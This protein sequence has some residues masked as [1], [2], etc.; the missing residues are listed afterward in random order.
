MDATGWGAGRPESADRDPASPAPGTTIVPDLWQQEAIRGLL[1][2]RDVVV[3]APTGAG[4]TYVFEKFVAQSSSVQAVYT[5]PTRALAND[6]LLEWRSAGWNVGITT[7]DL[8]EN[9]EAPVVVA[10]LETQRPHL[11]RGVGPDLLVIDEYQMLNDPLRGLH[12]EIA[13]ASAPAPTQLLLLSGSTEN[14]EL[15]VEWLQRLGRDPLLVQCPERPV[16]LEEINLDALRRKIPA[17]VKGYWPRPIAKALAAG[18]GPILLFAPQR[19]VAEEIARRLAASLPRCE[20]LELTREQSALARGPLRKML[21]RRVAYHHSG[22]DYRLR[23]GVIEP[24]AKNGQ[25]RVVVATTGLAAGINF[26]LRSVLVTDTQYRYG[27]ELRRIRPDELL[28]MFGRAGRRGI[29]PVGYVLTGAEKPRLR[30]ARSLTLQPN[31]RIDWQAC[32]ITLQAGASGPGDPVRDLAEL[33]RRFL[34]AGKLNLGL[35]EELPLRFETPERSGDPRA[36]PN[37]QVEMCNPDGE[38]ERLGKKR[39][40]P[41]GEALFHVRGRWRPALATPDLLRKVKVGAPARLPGTNPARHGR[42]LTVALF[43]EEEERGHLRLTKW[44]RR[45]LHRDWQEHRDYQRPRPECSLETLEKVYLP[46]LPRFTSGGFLHRWEEVQGS[47]RVYLD[48]AQAVTFC[49]IDQ[50]G[51]GLINPPVR[52]TEAEAVPDLQVALGSRTEERPRRPARNW[53]DLGLIDSRHRP[54]R[55]GVIFSFFSQG[56][57]LAVA[58]G[59]EDDSLGLGDLIFQLA[60]LR[61]GHRFEE[62]ENADSRLGD[63]SRM[64]YGWRTIPGYLKR[65]VPPEYGEGAAEVVAALVAGDRS[66]HEFES[67]QVHAGDMERALLE[68]RSLLRQILHA[69]DFAWDRWTELKDLVRT[70]LADTSPTRLEGLPTLSPEQR[71][72]REF[73]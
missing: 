28:Q 56:E 4:K 24:L 6:K 16:P 7:G 9:T 60:N 43:P 33:N 19:Q 57:G 63:L 8:A 71:I 59:L 1:A 41:L 62:I 35:D 68:W 44:F 67:A 20:P 12:Y 26:S 73:R 36:G 61:A 5:V 17:G 65:G 13:I 50:Q 2:G 10:T 34:S 49:R 14:P 51:R 18:L 55:R 70:Y 11:L 40:L 22:L 27:E 29:D 46:R 54:T 32:L 48:Y 38:W 52:Q 58:A 42:Q 21:S 47:I 30:D 31:R 69:P 23:A 66:F 39:R 37:W 15:V 53:F 25:I 3:D 45:A 64:K 72:R